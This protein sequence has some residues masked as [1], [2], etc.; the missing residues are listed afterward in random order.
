MPAHPKKI[1]VV[2]DDRVTLL[3]TGRKLSSFGYHVITA[4]DPADTISAV[5]SEKPDLVLLDVSFPPD[6]A[7]GGGVSWDGF[8]LVSWLRRMDEAKNTPIVMIS[9]DDSSE[10]IKRARAVGASGFFPKPINYEGLATVLVQLLGEPV[11]DPA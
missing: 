1:L 4:S 2:D 8:L 10:Q 5:R 11:A 9:V 7:H 3:A 6:V